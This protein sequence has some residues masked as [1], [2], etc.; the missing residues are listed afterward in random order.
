MSKR[1]L[2]LKAENFKRLV[3][4]HIEPGTGNIVPIT[5]KNAQGKTSVLDAI[6]SALAGKAAM[7]DQPVR[8]GEDDGAIEVKIGN[9]DEWLNV[10]RVFDAEGKGTIVVTNQENM[11]PATPQKLLDGLYAAVAFDPVEFIRM[12]A[13]EQHDSLRQLVTL[14]VDI[15]AVEQKITDTYEKRRDRNRDIK[16]DKARL[17]QMPVHEDVGKVMADEAEFEA[18]I[19]SAAEE[20]EKYAAMRSQ[21]DT[22]DTEIAS[23]VEAIEQKQR[24]AEHLRERISQ[25]EASIETANQERAQL[26]KLLDNADAIPERVDVTAI[27]EALKQARV[28]N[29][30]IKANEERALLA[31]SITASETESDKL[32]T[33]IDELKASIVKAFENADMPVKGLTLADGQVMFNDVPLTQASAAEQLRVSTAVGM[34]SNPELRVM[35]VR[36]ASLLDK[37]GAELLA[38]MAEENDF[39]IWME[40]VSD[41]EGAGIVIEDGM[42]KGAETPEPIGKKKPKQEGGAQF[43]KMKAVHEGASQSD[44]KSDGDEKGTDTPENADIEPQADEEQPEQPI[45]D[46]EEP[47]EDN[48]D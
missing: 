38:S 36:D 47:E 39:Q 20:N 40:T 4:V 8:K 46:E 24:E 1:I 5:G 25:I 16:S 22:A 28:E 33:K 44:K 15:D 10:R 26:Q 13:D 19:E 11:K 23:I 7:P 35:L 29:R 41:G 18:Q 17:G 37:D 21:R 27:S 43:E 3:A 45:D 30:K 34:A 48:A 6:E 42:V 2:E 9:E 31:K 14:D 32:T 12:K